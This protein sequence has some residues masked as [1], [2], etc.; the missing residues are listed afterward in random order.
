MLILSSIISPIQWIFN[1]NEFPLQNANFFSLF[2]K[3][4]IDFFTFSGIIYRAK[5]SLVVMED[6]LNILKIAKSSLDIYYEIHKDDNFSNKRN[7]PRDYLEWVDKK[8][9]IIINSPEF[10][11]KTKECIVRGDVVWVEFW[12]NIG[13]EF[14]GRHPAVVL[15]NG[16]KTLLVLPVT[17]KQPTEKQLSS[18]TYIELGKIYNFKSMKRWVNIFNI[19]PISIERIDFTKKKGNVKGTDLDNIS[20]A[21]LDSDLFRY[22]PPKQANGNK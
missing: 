2:W 18:N 6:L 20:K 4:S 16:G 22:L 5:G 17:S 15:K 14:S 19:T 8:T 9:K 3:K 1:L 12:F 7:T 13:E 11:K 21:F 10:I